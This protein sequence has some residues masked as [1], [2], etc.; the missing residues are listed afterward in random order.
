MLKIDLFLVLVTLALTPQLV[1]GGAWTLA[2]GK[3]AL[4]TAIFYQSTNSRFCTEQDAQSLAFN[5]VGCQSAG[6]SAPFDPFVGGES[7]AL[8]IFTEVTYGLIPGMNIGLQVPFYSLE[9]TNA[10][11]P[12]RPRNNSF[13]DIRFFTKYQVLRQPIVASLAM[14]AKS[15]T[16]KFTIDAEAVNVSE[17]QWDFDFWGEISKSFWPFKGYASM[18]AGYRLREDNPSFEQTVANELFFMAEVG[19]NLFS[20]LLIKSNVDWLKSKRPRIKSTATLLSER[21]ELLT[22][23]P[24]IIYSP[25]KEIGIEAA[26]RY[27]LKGRDF[28]DGPQFMLALTYQFSVL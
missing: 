28:P 11:N 12:N 2:K 7:N 14:A 8:A 17:G 21:R 4:K 18:G 22:I 20:D 10:S 13:G 23:T 15:P 24:S 25:Y 1:F 5:Q 6:D 9:F 19:Y 27:P 26:I 3:L 16:G